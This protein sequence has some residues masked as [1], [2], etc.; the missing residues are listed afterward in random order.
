LAAAAVPALAVIPLGWGNLQVSILLLG[1]ALAAN[2]F[3]SYWGEWAAH[4]G[5]DDGPH[6]NFLMTLF[7]ALAAW[8]VFR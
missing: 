6:T 8:I 1:I 3:E 4:R 5:M 7:A 2:V